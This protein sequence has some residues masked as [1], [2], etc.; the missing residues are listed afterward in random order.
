MFLGLLFWSCFRLGRILEQMEHMFRVFL[1]TK[2]HFYSCVFQC[3]YLY[4]TLSFLKMFTIWP[5]M[6]S[7]QVPGSTWVI[8]E[9]RGH[10]KIDVASLIVQLNFVF[11]IFFCVFLVILNLIVIIG[12]RRNWSRTLI[13]LLR[14]SI[15]I[16]LLPYFC[17]VCLIMHLSV[18][19]K[20]SIVR[21]LDCFAILPF[22]V[23]H[24]TLQSYC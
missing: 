16:F 18:Q 11:T 7:F 9:K 13:S 12:A 22:I 14:L 23:S 1:Q 19:C 3:R 20:W 6:C 2:Y 15:G 17:L 5:Q 8:V 24:I 4:W 21:P 10:L